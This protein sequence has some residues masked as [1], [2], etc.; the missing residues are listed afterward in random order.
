MSVWTQSYSPIEYIIIDGASTDETQMI[1]EKHGSKIQQVVIESDEGIY[2]AMNKGIMRATGDIIGFLNADDLYQN[3][4]VVSDVVRQFESDDVDA[5]YGDLVYVDMHNTGIVRRYWQAK[6]NREG[7]SNKFRVPPH[8][9]FFVRKAVYEKYGVFNPE[10]KLAADYELMARFVG[11][12][13]INAKYLPKVLVRMR[14]GGATNNSIGNIVRQ[15]L[16]ILK[17]NKINDI[18]VP[19]FSLLVSKG[20]NRLKQ[21]LSRPPAFH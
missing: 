17:A 13:K 5:C 18:R 7:S 12:Y 2:D 9:T 4:S 11:K 19:A 15:N 3:T 8:P 14:L 6:D 21:F 1:L 10:F 16:E 20:I